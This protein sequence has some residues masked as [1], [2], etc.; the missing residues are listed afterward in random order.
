MWAPLALAAALQATPAQTGD[1]ALKNA[2]PSHSV[3]GQTRKDA[4]YLGGDLIILNY[5]LQNLKVPE[6][7]V[8]RYSLALEVTTKGGKSIY[9]LEPMEFKAELTVGGTSRPALSVYEIPLD[10]APGDYVFTVTGADLQSKQTAKLEY[11]FEVLPPRLGFIQTGLHIPTGQGLIPTP[12]SVPVGQSVVFGTA[13]VG[14]EL[15]PKSETDI[16][17]RQPNLMLEMRIVDEATGKAT[18]ANPKR[19]GFM[20]VRDEFKR[21]IPFTPLLELNR[22]GKYRIEIKATDKHGGKTAEMS[23]D[24][25]VY[26]IK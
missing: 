23:L 20:E 10:M 13:V 15:G 2:R 21:V 3:L 22:P 14:F 19:E 6:D 8:V 12:L 17:K 5:D 16:K 18:L 11:A 4:K 1:F 25:T 26:E 7:S 24:I 9:K